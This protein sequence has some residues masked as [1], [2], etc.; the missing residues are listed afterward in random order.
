V[1]NTIFQKWNGLLM[2]LPKYFSTHQILSRREAERAVRAGKVKVNG[3]IEKNPARSIL[4]TDKVEIVGDLEEKTTV[5][6]NK[7][8]GI[9]SSKIA[10]EGTNIFD[11]LPQFS[12]LNAV[13]R[14]DKE[15]EGLIFLSNDGVLA[16]VLTGDHLIEKEYLVEV[17]EEVTQ[18]K[19]N[20]FEKGMVLNDGLTLPAKAQML[21]PH[22]F[23]LTL[24][25]GRNHQV[26][27]MANKVKLTILKL[28]RVRIGLITLDGMKTGEFRKLTS[29]EVK[30]LKG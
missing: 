14:L 25:E 18:T 7:P 9:S 12:A 10:D 15:S 17:R 27:R 26:R 4:E 28:K 20:A 24:K 5:A 11:L 1:K 30:A 16:K 8:R 21:S 3:V 2:N 19:L 22:S 13:G 23:S 6:F 29:K